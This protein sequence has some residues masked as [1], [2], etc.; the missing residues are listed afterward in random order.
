MKLAAII[1]SVVF[2]TN[3]QNGRQDSR[4]SFAKLYDIFK[5]SFIKLCFF[6]RVETHRNQL[7]LRLNIWVFVRR[8]QSHS[9]HISLH[10]QRNGPSIHFPINTE[11]SIESSA[12]PGIQPSAGNMDLTKYEITTTSAVKFRSETTK[13]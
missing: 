13:A 10:R 6:E 8:W 4:K 3:F 7:T 2:M 11:F 12:P 1:F 9:P 5:T